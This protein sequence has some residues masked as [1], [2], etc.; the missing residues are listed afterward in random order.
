MPISTYAGVKILNYVLGLTPAIAPPATYYVGLST[1]AIAADGTGITEPA[2]GDYARAAIANDKTDLS[3]ASAVSSVNNAVAVS[4]TTSTGDW[5][6]ITDI[7]ISDAITAGNMWYYKSLTT[8][9]PVPSGTTVTFAI[10]S[11][12]AT[13]T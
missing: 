9:I 10:G 4:L 12:V 7:F 1:T 8:P 13:L 6:T 5:G 3:I 2:G 11:I